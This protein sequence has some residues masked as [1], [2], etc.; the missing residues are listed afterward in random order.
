MKNADK[1]RDPL[2]RATSDMRCAARKLGPEEARRVLAE[3]FPAEPEGEATLYRSWLNDFL[4]VD[5]F[6]EHHGLTMSQAH[7]VIER[8]R[9]AQGTDKP[10]TYNPASPSTSRLPFPSEA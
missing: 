1:N 3:L 8:Q 2:K 10:R 5:A 9:K 7:R 4:S 6:A